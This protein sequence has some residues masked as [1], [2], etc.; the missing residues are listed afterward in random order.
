MTTSQLQCTLDGA[1]R[2][3]QDWS[4]FKIA[5]QVISQR[6]GGAVTAVGFFLQTLQSNR[7]QIP[8]YDGVQQARRGGFAVDHLL[9]RRHHRVGSERRAAGQAFVE[10]R[11]QRIHV[12]SGTVQAPL[13]LSLF[14]RHVAESARSSIL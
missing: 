7:F 10:D 5:L 2:T 4:V 8:G 13:A 6:L 11:A 3:S 9:D 12:A 1:H 14:G